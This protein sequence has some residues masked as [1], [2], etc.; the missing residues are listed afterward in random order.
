MRKKD[1]PFQRQFMLR[2]GLKTILLPR[3]AR[4]KHNKEKV[5]TAVRFS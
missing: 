1:T 2:V 4:A 5:E 3:Q